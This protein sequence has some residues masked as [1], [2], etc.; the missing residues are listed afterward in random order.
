M[1]VITSGQYY[2][3]LITKWG[4]WISDQERLKRTRSPVIGLCWSD[5]SST[6][7][8]RCEKTGLQGFWP[9]LTQTRLYSHRRW[10]EA[11]NFRF[12]KKRDCTICVAKTKALISFAVTAKLIC[13]FVF[14]YAK[15]RFSH[16][17]ATLFLAYAIFFIKRLIN[18]GKSL[19]VASIL[20][21]ICLLRVIPLVL[22]ALSTKSVVYLLSTKSFNSCIVLVDYRIN[23]LSG[24]RPY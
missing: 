3:K 8:P 7:V 23:S 2:I 12:R 4:F 9:G 16:D 17:E 21:V 13:V 10:L 11:W 24:C 6:I 19:I 5:C 20:I 14:A 22:P 18:V 1:W 15:K